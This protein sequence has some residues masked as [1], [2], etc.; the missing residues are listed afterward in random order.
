[1]TTM[2]LRKGR[3]TLALVVATVSSF[4]AAS[5]RPEVAWATTPIVNGGGGAVGAGLP[6]SLASETQALATTDLA[7]GAAKTSYP[8]VLPRARGEAQ[9]SLALRYDSSQGVGPAG[10]GWSLDLPSIARRGQAGIP[11]FLDPIYNSPPLGPSIG[12]EDDYYIGGSLLIP[13]PTP[14][15]LPAALPTVSGTPVPGVAARAWTMWRTEVDDGNRYFFDATTWVMQTKSGH[16][17]EFGAPLDGGAPSVEVADPIT[18]GALTQSPLGSSGT[19]PIYRW[20]L[21]RDRD[22]SGNVVYYNWST[23]EQE[24]FRGTSGLPATGRVMYLVDIYDTG[25]A[26]GS[27]SGGGGGASTSPGGGCPDGQTSCNG[28][29]VDMQSDANNCGAC[30]SICGSGQGCQ[31]GGCK[32]LSCPGQSGDCDGKPGNGC[33]INLASDP[34]NCGACGH[35]CATGAVCNAA[36]CVATCTGPST[37]ACGNCGTQ[38][39]TCNAGTW[40]AWG[41]CTGQGACA[42]GATQACGSGGTQSCTAACAWGPCGCPSGQAACSGGCKNL[43]ADPSNCGACGNVCVGPTGGTATCA[44]GVCGATCAAGQTTCSGA[45]KNLQSDSAN[46]GSCGN[47]CPSGT[48]CSAGTCKKALGAACGSGTDCASQICAQ[49]VCCATTCPASCQSCAVPGSVGFC[50]NVPAGGTDPAGVCKDQGAKTCGT[51]GLCNGNAGCALYAA[52]VT[53]AAASCPGGTST[54]ISTRTCDGNGTCKPGVQT[55]CAPYAC[56]GSAKSIAPA[57]VAGTSACPTSCASDA[58]CATGFVCNAGTCGVTCPSGLA[59]CGGACRNLQSD[60]ANCGACGTACAAGQACCSGACKNIQT[61]MSNCGGCGVVCS[62]KKVSF[63]SCTAGVCSG[64][65]VSP[66][67]DCDHNLQIDGCEVNIATDLNNCGGCGIVCSANHVTPQCGDGTAGASKT[68]AG[69][70]AAGFGDCN[71]NKQSDG[72]ETPLNTNANCGACGNVCTAGQACSGGAC[73]SS[74]VPSCSGRVCGNDNCGGSCGTCQNGLVCNNGACVPTSSC[75]PTGCTL[76]SREPRAPA[77][78]LARAMTALGKLIEGTAHAD[79]PPNLSFAHHVHLT[80]T[81]SPN[82]YTGASPVWKS[83]YL[84]QLTTVDVSSAMADASSPRRLV[85]EYQLGYKYNNT[86]TRAYL[87]SVQMVGDCDKGGGISEDTT[88]FIASP[89]PTTCAKYPATA[90]GYTG[91]T[92]LAGRPPAALPMLVE[93]PSFQYYYPLS[94]VD[95][96]G[97][98]LVDVVGFKTGFLMETNDIAQPFPPFYADVQVTYGNKAAP[99]HWPA[100]VSGNGLMW[101]DLLGHGAFGEW[102]YTGALSLLWFLPA[103]TACAASDGETCGKPPFNTGVFASLTAGRADAYLLAA[104][105]DPPAHVAI[106]PGVAQALG[107][108]P[109]GQIGVGI[110]QWQTG[111][112]SDFDGDGLPDMMLSSDI[113]SFKLSTPYNTYISTSDRGG[114]RSPMLANG[115]QLCPTNLYDPFNYGAQGTPYGPN[116]T[117]LGTRAIA[118]MDGDGLADLVV[119]S[120][121]GSNKVVLGVLPSRGD[122][123]FGYPRGSRVGADNWGPPAGAVAPFGCNDDTFGAQQPFSLTTTTAIGTAA[124]ATVEAPVLSD[125]YRFGDLNGDGFA[126]MAVLGVD[127]L[128]VCLFQR[129]GRGQYACTMDANLKGTDHQQSG[130][131]ADIEIGDVYGTGINQVIYFPANTEDP[132]FGDANP[133]SM[134]ATAISIAPNGSPIVSGGRPVPR[135]GLLQKIANGVGA[136][137]TFTYDTVA[138]QGGKLPTP[139]WVVKSMT[140]S[141]NMGND[142]D[143]SIQTTFTYGTPI[144]DPHDRQFVGFDSVTTVRDGVKPDSNSPG[145]WTKTTFATTTCVSSDAGCANNGITYDASFQHFTRALPV[146]VETREWTGGAPGTRITSVLDDYVT[147]TPYSALDGRFGIAVQ[148]ARRHTY[149]WDEVTQAST[150]SSPTVVQEINLGRPRVI[151][152]PPVDLPAVQLVV[153]RH[154]DANGNLTDV[155]DYGQSATDQHILT[156]YVPTL[157][158]NDATGWS[159]RVGTSQTNYAS[160]RTDAFG[161]M[162]AE[163]SQP[164]REYDFDYDAWGRVQAVKAPLSRSATMPSSR[165][166]APPNAPTTGTVKLLTYE[167]EPSGNVAAIGSDQ[168]PCKARIA[169]DTAFDHLAVA[170]TAF[171]GGCNTAGLVTTVAYDRRFDALTTMTSPAGEMAVRAYDDFGRIAEIDAQDPSSTLPGTMVASKTTYED[172]GPVRHVHTETA[173]GP[174]AN[175]A[176]GSPGGPALVGTPSYMVKHDRYYDGLG[177]LRA[178]VDEESF[179]TQ[180]SVAGQPT[181]SLRF[182]LSGLHT[183]YGNGRVA[184]SYRPLLSAGTWKG[185]DPTVAPTPGVALAPGGWQFSPACTTQNPCPKTASTVYDGLG[186]VVSTTDFLGA[187]STWKYHTAAMQVEVRDREQVAGG[188]VAFTTVTSDSHGR[189]KT[190]DRSLSSTATGAAHIVTSYDAYE[191]TG[192]PKQITH[193]GQTRSMQ[194]DSLGRLAINNEPNSGTWLYAYDVD[195]RLAG[196]SDARGCGQNIYYDGIGRM[197]ARDYMPC[198]SSSSW[199]QPDLASGDGTEAFYKY[200]PTTGR[201]TDAFDLARHD[202]Y[203]YDSRGRVISLARQMVA[204]IGVAPPSTSLASRYTAQ[205]F[206]KTVTYDVTDRV[207]TATTGATAPELNAEGTFESRSYGYEGRLQTLQVAGG[208]GGAAPVPLLRNQLYNPD[209]SIN[210]QMFGDAATVTPATGIAARTQGTQ[211]SFGYDANGT[212]TSYRLFRDNGPWPGVSTSP[213]PSSDPNQATEPTLQGELA[214]LTIKP[215]LVGNPR[216]VGDG[217]SAV[218]PGGAKSVSQTYKYWDDYRLANATSN[219][220]GD[221]FSSP[222]QGDSY[223]PPV[224]TGNNVPARWGNDWFNY[225]A[226][227]NI[228]SSTDGGNDFFERS[229]GDALYTPGTD[230]LQSAGT[231]TA[232]TNYAGLPTVSYDAAGNL[233]S[234]EVTGPAGNTLSFSYTWDEAGRL[235]TAS[236]ED[237]GVSTMSVSESYVYDADGNRVV[238]YQNPDHGG[239]QSYTVQVF[240]SLVLKN[241]RA[242]ASNDIPATYTYQDDRTTEQVY[243]GGGMAR[244]FYDSGSGAQALPSVG[245]NKVHIFMT[246]TDQRGS[247]TFVIDHDTGEIVERTSYQPYGAVDADYRPQR[248]NTDREDVRY[249][250]HWDN[251]EVGLVYM[252][253]RYY[254]PQL[255]R[256]ISPDPLTVHGLM[257]DGN[258]YEYA[259]GSPIRFSDPS[260]LSP[261]GC[262]DCDGGGEKEGGVHGGG[263]PNLA[264][265]GWQVWGQGVVNGRPYLITAKMLDPPAPAEAEAK[266]AADA[267]AGSEAQAEGN[268][269]AAARDAEAQESI[270]MTDLTVAAGGE[271]G[272]VVSGAGGL[273]ATHGM[274]AAGVSGHWEAH[275]YGPGYSDQFRYGLE[276]NND[277]SAQKSAIHEMIHEGAHE[278]ALYD[279]MTEGAHGGHP[280]VHANG[281]PHLGHFAGVGAMMGMG[282][283]LEGIGIGIGAVAVVQSNNP[284]AEGIDQVLGAAGSSIASYVAM[285][286]IA[287]VEGGPVGALIGAAVGGFMGF[288]LVYSASHAVTTATM[289]EH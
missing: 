245:G 102:G 275:D 146:L 159:F 217:A 113:R 220:V 210:S 115:W 41:A 224:T 211:T 43:Q 158:P 59:F 77:G 271:M 60:A 110:G 68:C 64:F 51:D 46:C 121:D 169:Y 120:K 71:N 269:R 5:L 22:A 188:H 126:D 283:L 209:G 89:T 143:V 133:P 259:S 248:W 99:G 91:V 195:G 55:S 44:G 106:D 16:V 277:T 205:T 240:D 264:S 181:P 61:D 151:T 21:V 253:A 184:L 281:A 179:L 182:V 100:M 25:S 65:C 3:Y 236:R 230:Q 135:D 19:N 175:G 58:G 166:A 104:A 145:L 219:D 83:T 201:L 235:A 97:D 254:S 49:G 127:G 225:D 177:E 155:I 239:A 74:C 162:S 87:T 137:T 273:A 242:V 147:T 171:P 34:A 124:S 36:T 270:S 142:Q 197:L 93:K 263:N 54:A 52:G 167:Y 53:C 232:V 56:L 208:A 33:E 222:T 255:M 262:G 78:K 86:L 170:V 237:T 251:A 286:A 9:P 246:F 250:G 176:I 280:G 108:L 153:D 117:F 183:S 6:T 14:S 164:T 112:F 186:R 257:G 228:T 261:T 173:G 160:V 289:G 20:N 122:G 31:G 40:S 192:E 266:G 109:L 63:P 90:Y 226:R 227:G 161:Q 26:P 88:G 136:T 15:S 119:V 214:K 125:V 194:Y 165:P 81:A 156:H 231:S 233:Q 138:N 221:S 4:V 150:S 229:L 247:T 30:G 215:D 1:M 218:W 185:G 116:G 11:R 69:A 216:S 57:S 18:A 73:V 13:V 48:T 132:L 92:L 114:G 39:R 272:K 23:L 207:L 94:V 249:G 131:Q 2:K 287:G 148:S 279:W 223:Y 101:T 17:V 12:T 103:G 189:V 213:S 95:V 180:S 243:L 35:A 238:T 172:A 28:I 178:A 27:A 154:F 278:N 168:N 196:V 96:D 203:G 174:L 152:L 8:F 202:S 37:Q 79:P 267:A 234:M 47:A 82:L 163:V 187:Q 157:P 141:N 7:T 191:A 29:C 285:G 32:I 98:S 256:F 149:L 118:D 260:G 193:G 76:T 204:P 10:V 85:R 198:T 128:W 288:F 62:N 199:K 282:G 134:T 84:A 45:C 241:A 38:S 80:W 140:T 274:A 252:G 75:P 139:Q 67:A 206:T 144:Y 212:L 268:K 72:C 244:M 258:P 42:P 190:V 129:V 265:G 107:R 200:D 66:V 111:R 105:T 24:L 123:R 50:K 276:W 284:W 70:C 130:S